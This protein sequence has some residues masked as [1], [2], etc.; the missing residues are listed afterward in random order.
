MSDRP[1]AGDGPRPPRSS[2]DRGGPRRPPERVMREGW[3]ETRIFA[4]PIDH[5]GL[6]WPERELLKQLGSRLYGK[7]RQGE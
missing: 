3:H 2:L 1:G 5:A 7:R 4:V 6:T